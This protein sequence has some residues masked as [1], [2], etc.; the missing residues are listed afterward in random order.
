MG[1]VALLFSPTYGAQENAAPAFGVG[2]LV[3]FTESHPCNM[4]VEGGQGRII[5]EGVILRHPNGDRLDRYGPV[6]NRW[7]IRVI[8]ANGG[9]AKSRVTIE[10]AHLATV[11]EEPLEDCTICFLPVTEG[12]M[13]RTPCCYTN[14][15]GDAWHR[16]CLRNYLTQ[17]VINWD[18][19]N[20]PVR[21]R[22]PK[23]RGDWSAGQQ[24]FLARLQN[25]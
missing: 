25:A 21:H 14:D 16:D 13:E 2:V 6:N 12:D 23:C 7:S 20:G 8:D 19:D 15:G 1:T 18:A 9:I 17:T 10:E 4:Y 3:N 11:Y 24:N 5:E 22:C